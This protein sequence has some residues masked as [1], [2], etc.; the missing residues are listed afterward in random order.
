MIIKPRAIYFVSN[1]L[2]VNYDVDGEFGRNLYAPGLNNKN[3]TA[4]ISVKKAFIEN[5]VNLLSIIITL[6]FNIFALQ[7]D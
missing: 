2:A 3:N 1:N 6:T 5:K 4:T 7:Y